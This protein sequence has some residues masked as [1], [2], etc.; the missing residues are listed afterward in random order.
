MTQREIE[1]LLQRF[2]DG[3]LDDDSCEEVVR[4]L[5]ND[6]DIFETYCEYAE[7]DAGL[8]HLSSGKAA[9]YRPGIAEKCD[10][11]EQAREHQSRRI[12]NISL[13][14]SVAAILILFLTLS[15]I[16]LKPTPPPPATFTTGPDTIFTL[17]H[18]D[19]VSLI[20]ITRSSA[21]TVRHGLVQVSL[22]GI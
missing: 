6:P 1:S 15:I 8:A 7:L 21:F 2:V 17:S 11:S 12:R 22:S 10:I 5:K 13:L 19:D 20:L 4:L 9:A 18:P 3:R 16:W 14:S